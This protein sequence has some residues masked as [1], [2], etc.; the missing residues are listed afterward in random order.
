M[1]DDTKPRVTTTASHWG[2]YEIETTKG[3]I[4]GVR[5]VADDPDPSPIGQSF[6]DAVQ[7]RVRVRAPMVREGFLANGPGS[8]EGRGRDG[9]VEVTWNEAFDLVARELERIRATHGNAA[10]YAGSY[11]WASAGRFH[12]A[13]SQLRRFLNLFGGNVF[14]KNSYSLGAA[15]VLLPRIAAS[16]F[17]LFERHTPWDVIAEHGALVVAFGGLPLKN[18]QVNAGGVGR[19]TAFASMKRAHDNGVHFVNISPVADDIPPEL[20]PEWLAAIPN[21]DTALMMGL[22]HTLVAEGLHD[23]G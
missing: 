13:Q 20:E 9:F 11:G 7:H 8:G 12:H 16:M 6:A 5:P 22:A 19:H 14:H 2:T 17:E 10:I 21:S 23:R 4:T 18:A 1:P 3:R 15:H